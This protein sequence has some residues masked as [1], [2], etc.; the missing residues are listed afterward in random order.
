LTVIPPKVMSA[1]LVIVP[2]SES[3]GVT[4]SSRSEVSTNEDIIA[5]REAAPVCCCGH[6]KDDH[7]GGAAGQRP[8]DCIPGGVPFVCP[9]FVRREL[10][11][12]R[13]KG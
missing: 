8:R 1:M 3:G 13:G 7:V 10:Q 11:F 6:F 12:P 4:R 5:A 9:N 2:R